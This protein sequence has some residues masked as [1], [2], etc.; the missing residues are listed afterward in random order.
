MTMDVTMDDND[1]RRKLD[2]NAKSARKII[3]KYKMVP[4]QVSHAGF[5]GRY[6]G[7]PEHVYFW[8]GTALYEAAIQMAEAGEFAAPQP[9]SMLED[10]CAHWGE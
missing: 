6:A 1:N 4:E 2:M 9:L 10:Y 5:I 7:T 8:K 3:A